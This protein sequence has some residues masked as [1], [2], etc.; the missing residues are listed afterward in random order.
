MVTEERTGGVSRKPQNARRASVH[1]DAHR[2]GREIEFATGTSSSYTR[3]ILSCVHFSSSRVAVAGC[4]S[5]NA[6]RDARDTRRATSDAVAY[7]AAT[8][9]RKLLLAFFLFLPASLRA[10]TRNRRFPGKR[11]SS[12]DFFGSLPPLERRIIYRENSLPSG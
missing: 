11:I 9:T 4:A 1:R 10:L 3:R 5:K 2:A 8:S 7:A 12:R 6:R